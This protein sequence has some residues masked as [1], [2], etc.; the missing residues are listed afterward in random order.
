M[1]RSKDSKHDPTDTGILLPPDRKMPVPKGR[2]SEPRLR[3]T[4]GGGGHLANRTLAFVAGGALIAGGIAGFLLRPKLMKD[5]RVVKLETS[6][7]EARKTAT[8]DRD[9]AATSE[10]QL[11]V[12]TSAKSD[13]EKQLEL[14]TK[15]K[16]QLA[17]KAADAEKKAKEA[18]A[19]QNKLKAA[20]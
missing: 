3:P 20:I 16:T 6:L 8:T 14:A 13:L 2:D 7:V 18:L 11:K 1:A 12:V 9:R 15:A 10:S 5:E 4:Y 19:V 17:D